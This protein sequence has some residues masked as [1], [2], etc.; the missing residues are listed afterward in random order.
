MAADGGAA[1][2]FGNVLLGQ[3]GGTSQGRL[4]ITP[5]G[6]TWRR[7]GGG[8]T[9]EVPQSDIQGLYWSKT[10]QGCQL[11]VQRNQERLVQL[12]GFREKDLAS[13]R[14]AIA[15]LG[16]SIEE[17]ELAVSGRNWG[18]AAVQGST[19]VFSV[20]SKPAFCVPLK[21]VGGVQQAAQ[22]VMLEFPMDDAATGEREDALVEMSFYVPKEAEGFAGEGED[23]SVKV[24]Y[25]RV[26]E[27]TEAGAAAAGDAIVTFDGVAVL[28]PRGRFEIEMY[29]TFL[30]LLGQAQDFRIQYDSIMR[31]FLLPKNNTPHTLVAI[32]LDP[33]IRKGQTYY[34]H[35]LVQFS[36]DEDLS[37]SLDISD[38]LLAAKN[39]KCGG[40]LQRELEGPAF[41]VFARVLRGLAATKLTKPGTFR[42]MDGDGEGHALRCSYK[43]DDGY[44]YPLE[45]AF[46]YVHKPPTLLVH[47]EIES[48]EF[49]RQ[50]GGVLA[51]SAKTF[52]LLIRMRNNSDFLFRGIQK[53]E[54][55]NLFEFIQAKR[56]RVENLDEA[57][58]GPGGGRALDLGD[59]IDNG[60]ARMEADGELDSEEDD[61]DFDE[62]AAAAAADAEEAEE[63]AEDEE[64]DEESPGPG[65]HHIWGPSRQPG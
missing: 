11:S 47:D 7:D 64:D 59:D 29:A 50:G 24:F 49:M 5:S 4:K 34:H 41:E 30:K 6:L 38:E 51:A 32:A 21:D 54:W 26:L 27:H 36:K 20:G 37:V 8:K 13:L 2:Q 57:A 14:E 33:P 58:G 62:R 31:L 48:I 22:E 52:D 25:D 18:A 12:T 53:S 63:E 23:P 19:L 17:Q 1:V 39:E 43:A 28:H 65:V 40:K 61:E 35:V 45:R 46:F 55:A 16:H 3:R 44:L 56:L 60:V 15:P 10:A 9:V 42:C